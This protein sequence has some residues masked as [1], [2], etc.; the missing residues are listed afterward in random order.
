MKSQEQEARGKIGH[1]KIMKPIELILFERYKQKFEETHPSTHFFYSSSPNTSKSTNQ[2]LNEIQSLDDP[3]MQDSASTDYL[4]NHN[5][6]KRRSLSFGG[7]FCVGSTSKN[8]EESRDISK[9]YCS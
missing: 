9:V 6:K 2:S 7:L 3:S 8:N 5:K 1:N 4:L